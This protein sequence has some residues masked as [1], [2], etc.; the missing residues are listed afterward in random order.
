MLGRPREAATQDPT[1]SR[2]GRR[3]ARDRSASAAD[4]RPP[5]TAAAGMEGENAPDAAAAGASDRLDFTLVPIRNQDETAE[6][7]GEGVVED[8][9]IVSSE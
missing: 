9:I 1:K 3:A 7:G 4:A 8:T 2:S 6:P 5:S